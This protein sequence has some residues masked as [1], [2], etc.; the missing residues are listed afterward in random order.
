VEN[1]I[2]TRERLVE[3]RYLMR[4]LPHLQ[5][6]MSTACG[7]ADLSRGTAE[8]P[9][10]IVLRHSDGANSLVAVEG[11]EYVW[12]TSDGVL[13]LPLAAEY[14]EYVSFTRTIAEES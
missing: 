2:V 5:A 9:P 6:T 12:E 13:R 1:T 4:L 3:V 7:Q 8:V 10:A 14:R 11:D